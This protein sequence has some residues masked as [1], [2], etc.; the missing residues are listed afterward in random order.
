MRTLILN[1]KIYN[2]FWSRD[3]RTESNYAALMTKD[4]IMGRGP[5]RK[6]GRTT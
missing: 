1:I 6:R 5:R 4:T 3:S 2:Q